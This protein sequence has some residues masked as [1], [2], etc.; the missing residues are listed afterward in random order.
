VEDSN[1]L[2]QAAAAVTP[3]P[4]VCAGPRRGRSGGSDG[5]EEDRGTSAWAMAIGFSHAGP[6]IDQ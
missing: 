5:D 3:S 1:S 2:L 4:A 6:V